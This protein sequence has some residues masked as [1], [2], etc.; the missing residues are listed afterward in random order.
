MDIIF[1]DSFFIIDENNNQIEIDN[2][3]EIDECE[4]RIED[5]ENL[6][7]ILI[8]RIW[9]T[10]MESDKYLMKEDLK[11]LIKLNDQYIFSS[12]TTNMYIAK[13]DNETEFNN[14]CKDFIFYL[15]KNV[16]QDW[17]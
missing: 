13:S 7:D 3:L 12:I 9:E 10:R 16:Q 1:K 14:I 2:D 8:W 15:K 6:I 4:W 5:R 11:Y 17:N